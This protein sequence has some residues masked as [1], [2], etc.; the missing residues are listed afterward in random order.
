MTDAATVSV[1]IDASPETVFGHLT[2][3]DK[4]LRWMGVSADFEARPGGPL[5]IDVNSEAQASGEFLEVVPFERVVFT[6]GWI[7]NDGV[8]PGSTTVAI[9]IVPVGDRTQVTLTH[10]GLPDQPARDQHAEGWTHYLGRLTVAAHGGDPGPDPFN[11]DV[12]E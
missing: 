11:T 8:P 3:R 12:T 10:S 5:R 7:G 4:V 2:Q 1:T 6:W 9:D